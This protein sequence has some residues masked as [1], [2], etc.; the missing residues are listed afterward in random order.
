MSQRR[1]Q[2]E[3]EIVSGWL[4]VGAVFREDLLNLT[5]SFDILRAKDSVPVVS[6][7]VTRFQGEKTEFCLSC[8]DLATSVIET[9]QT[10]LVFDFQPFVPIDQGIL[11]FRVLRVIEG[12]VVSAPRYK[13][14]RCENTRVSSWQSR[15]R[16]GHWAI[17]GG[18]KRT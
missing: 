9:V 6:V 3:N 11:E 4:R 2:G 18:G 12:N 1:L 5:G 14:Q 15:S 13:S 7:T 16:F 17:Q 10:Y 8:S